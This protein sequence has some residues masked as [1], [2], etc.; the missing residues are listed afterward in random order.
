MRCV[1]AALGV[2]FCWGA[3]GATCLLAADWPQWR[4]PHRDGV[5]QET[6]LLKEWPKDGPKV[7]WQVNDIGSGFSTPAVVGDRIYLLGNKGTDDEFVTALDAKDGNE[8]WKVSLGKVGKPD[9]RPKYPAARSTHTV[10]G[11]LLFAESSNGD[12]ACLETASGK[13]RWQ[14][15]LPDDFGG[16]SGNW[17]YA[18]SPLVDGD[19]VV[20]TP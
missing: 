1:Q 4:G 3:L 20:C 11:E 16:H 18:E 7:V 2:I 9:Q 5:S 19:S 17:A 15:S 12:L 10:D 13:K 14:K 8:V 6:G